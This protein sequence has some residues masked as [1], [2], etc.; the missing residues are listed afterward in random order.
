MILVDTSVWIDHLRHDDPVL[1]Q[2]LSK[3]QVLS[4]P[5]IIGELALG[6]LRQRDLI[7]EALR[8]LPSVIV[9][10]DEEVHAFIDLHRLFGIGI[11]YIDAHLLAA[12]LLTP[13]VQFWTRDKRLRAAAL[14][15]GVDAN[16][17]H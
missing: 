10:H 2:S 12:T 16:L 1:S 17:D 15:L 7:L 3:R 13:D 11:G 4:H 14:R 8:G 9:A 6:S 5:F